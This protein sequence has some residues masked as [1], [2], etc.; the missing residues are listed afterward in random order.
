M[1]TKNHG[2]NIESHD[3]PKSVDKASAWHRLNRE[4]KLEAFNLRASRS[5]MNSA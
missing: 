4:G 2:D 1:V 3:E 5:E